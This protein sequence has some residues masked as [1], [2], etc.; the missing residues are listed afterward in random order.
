MANKIF[1]SES[2]DGFSTGI[3][4]LKTKINNIING[5]QVVSKATSATS[6]TYATY[7]TKAGTSNYSKDSD[8]ATTAT[9][10]GTATYATNAGTATYAKGV[11]AHNHTVANI[12][13]LTVTA[14][15]L[16]YM[17]GVTSA[18]QTQ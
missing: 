16:N 10:A 1:T 3:A 17:D 2:W 8:K 5:T 14:T 11:A 15:E 9:N 7:A 4:N 6:A 18:V 13:D 12:S